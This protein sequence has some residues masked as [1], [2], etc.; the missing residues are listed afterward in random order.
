[1]KKKKI[2]VIQG[3]T[4]RER[5]ISLESA[6]SC[7]K[8]IKK[9]GHK[10]IK[11]DPKYSSSLNLQKI[12]SDVVFNSLHG[13]DGEDGKIQSI[14]EYLG[15]A[16]THSGVLSSMIAM[17]KFLSKQFFI[18]NKI[19][20][21][22]YIFI[23]IKE[24]KNINLNKELKKNKIK[25]PVVIKPNDEGSSI[26]VKICK[27]LKILKKEFFFLRKKYEYL[28]IENYI[29]G[30]EIQVAVMG[31]KALGAIELK[32]KR[33]FYD[34]KAK[35]RKS[36]NTKHIMP[37]DIPAKKYKEVLKI[38]EKAHAVLGCRGISRCDFRFYKRNFF[39]LE[40]NTQPGMTS[41]SLVPEIA[42]FVNIP[43]IKLVK[44]MIDDAS[45]NR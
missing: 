21:P 31:G 24:K 3:G 20:T 32:P 42:D 5:E 9:L 11:F 18:Q 1:M 25:F 28:I 36:S 17:D 15:K 4:S 6:K 10:V 22:N 27:N 33:K 41:L 43:F 26:G 2:V 39:L 19:K 34:Y 37:A 12:K 14:L 23:N 40:L 13:K 38:S 30:Q 7:I 45:I 44:W 16:Y 35:Y 8:A 29:P